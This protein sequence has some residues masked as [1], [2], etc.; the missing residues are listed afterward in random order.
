MCVCVCVF[1]V[2]VCV[3]ISAAA[4][5]RPWEELRWKSAVKVATV[6]PDA[7]WRRAGRQSCKEWLNMSRT[8]NY[9]KLS[10]V[11]M[12]EF[13]KGSPKFSLLFTVTNPLRRRVE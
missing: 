8:C 12:P 9:V 7:I 5:R 3:Y 2:Y 10:N 13:Q 6:V 4:R 11:S 1:R